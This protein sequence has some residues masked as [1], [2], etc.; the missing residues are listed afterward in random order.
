MSS[1]ASSSAYPSAPA[2]IASLIKMPDRCWLRMMILVF[3]QL[4]LNEAYCF[5]TIRSSHGNV[6][7]DKIW[8]MLSCQTYRRSPIR[9]FANDLK[10]GSACRILR[11]AFLITSLSSTTRVR[12]IAAI[13]FPSV[14]YVLAL[15]YF[16]FIFRK[17]RSLASRYFSGRGASTAFEG[18]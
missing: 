17:T 7:E 5:K 3:G 1:R 4:G 11:M 16:Y 10:L 12:K 9:G 14:K 13:V 15:E 18:S 2:A 8:P 6:D